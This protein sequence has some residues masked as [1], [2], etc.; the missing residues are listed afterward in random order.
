[1]IPFNPNTVHVMI[2]TTTIADTIM[3]H[4]L[5]NHERNE[6][7][8]LKEHIELQRKVVLTVSVLDFFPIASVRPSFVVC[9]PFA[10]SALRS[11]IERDESERS[12]SLARQRTECQLLLPLPPGDT[13]VC[14]E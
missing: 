1:M 12:P 8:Q 4:Q 3:K 14:P 10:V 13:L 2:P 6:P 11:S 5:R 7:N 9:V